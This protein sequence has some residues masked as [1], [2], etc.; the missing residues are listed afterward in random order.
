MKD[1]FH[2]GMKWT[3]LCHQTEGD[4]RNIISIADAFLKVEQHDSQS[5]LVQS[6]ILIHVLVGAREETLSDV[7]LS[8]FITGK[9]HKLKC[10]R[11]SV[12]C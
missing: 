8:F 11:F 3:R 2:L 4:K 6:N 5:V 1:I 10:S 9:K 7:V 12:V